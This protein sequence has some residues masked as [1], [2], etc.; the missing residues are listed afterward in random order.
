MT[1]HPARA[2][3]PIGAGLGLLLALGAGTPAMG[4]EPQVQA[5]IADVRAGKALTSFDLAT[6]M[7]ASEIWCYA[8]DADTCHWSDVYLDIDADGALY[9]IAFLWGPEIG[10]AHTGRMLFEANRFLCEVP[11]DWATT[12][13]AWEAETGAMIGGR[14]LHALRTEF[15]SVQ[16]WGDYCY[17]YLLVS[18]SEADA[19]ITLRQ[20]VWRDGETDPGRDAEVTLHFD[21]MRAE[22]LAL[23]P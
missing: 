15:A 2:G 3:L 7:A 16:E 4:F 22:A 19:T 8:E 17:D 21:A 6:V 10:I 14:S 11:G 9:E 12:M 5:V 18:T 13:R 1:H 20:R 23:R